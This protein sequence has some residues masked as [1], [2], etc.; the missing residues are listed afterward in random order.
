MRLVCAPSDHPDLTGKVRD[1]GVVLYGRAQTHGQGSAGAAIFE[2]IRRRKY[3]PAPKA[4]DFLS[5]AL[6][7]VAADGRVQRS[8]STDGWTRSIELRVSV[9][10]PAF[11]MAQT[12]LVQAML[13]FLTTDIWKVEFTG[14]GILPAAIKPVVR[15]VEKCVALLSGGLDSLIGALDLAASGRKPFVVSQAATGDKKNQQY[16]AAKIGGGLTH[17]QLNHNA[18]CPGPTERSQRSRSVVFYAYGILAATTLAAY[19]E[20][21]SIPLYASENG[22]ISINPPLTPARL[23]SLSTRTTHPIFIALLQQL[24]DAAGL[25]VQIKNLYQFKTKGEMLHGCADQDF[26]IKFAHT[27]TSCGRYGT[28][29]YKHCGRC[30]PCLIRR[31]AFLTWGTDDKTK[32]VYENLGQNDSAH[33]GFDDVRSAA[34]GV[35]T[36]KSEGIASVIGAGLS[37]PLIGDARPYHQVTERGLKEI[38]KLLVDQGVK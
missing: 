14:N 1:I 7:V 24:L 4:W 19:A 22:L 5:L 18:T 35:E 29:G 34:M 21:N 23:G 25:R 10:D 32:Y 26:L 11:W 33:A 6:A 30:L 38:G 37:S 9:N 20:G 2:Q 3:D 13:R 27:S 16:F 17:L 36:F 12:D 8:K 28:F 31:A 15:P